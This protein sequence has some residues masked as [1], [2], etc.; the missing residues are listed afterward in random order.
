MYVVCGQ[1]HFGCVGSGMVGGAMSAAPVGSYGATKPGSLDQREDDDLAVSP[2]HAAPLI[3][4]HARLPPGRALIFLVAAFAA[5]A[6]W[7]AMAGGRAQESAS[8]A[9]TEADGAAVDR[10]RFFLR[11]SSERLSA[12]AP[13]IGTPIDVANHE[14]DDIPV[15][16]PTLADASTGLYGPVTDDSDDPVESTKHAATNDDDS[17]S[18]AAWCKA[19]PEKCTSTTASDDDV[20]AG[21]D[22]GST[23]AASDDDSPASAAWCKAHPDKCAAS[24]S[25]SSTASDDGDDD[26]DDGDDEDG[27]DGNDGDGDNDALQI[28]VVWWD[29]GNTTATA[30]TSSN[31]SSSSTVSVAND[32]NTTSMADDDS[33]GSA[34]WCKSHK[35]KCSAESRGSDDGDDD[36]DD[37]ASTSASTTA[38][39]DD[40][41]GSDG[42]DDGASSSSSSSSSSWSPNDDDAPHSESPCDGRPCSVGPGGASSD[43]LA[44]AHEAAHSRLRP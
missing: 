7:F 18:S 37:D 26:G 32:D 20:R 27:D 34:A 13:S 11:R 30:T 38:S 22:G 35:S 15:L 2:Q 40:D 9:R 6:T 36:D 25:S 21:D 17:P 42:A 24:E 28:P 44:S 31:S 43:S 3:R 14:S 33:P 41:D 10:A 19:H 16:E 5:T 4:R 39:D 29:D 1:D 12:A 8:L 23:V